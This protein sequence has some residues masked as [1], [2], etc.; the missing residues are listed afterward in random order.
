MSERWGGKKGN[1]ANKGGRNGGVGG[2]PGITPIM[3][4]PPRAWNDLQD[5]H[6]N[7]TRAQQ[8]LLNIGT[9]VLKSANYPTP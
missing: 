5:D 4:F 9:G 6:Q 2:T 3:A 8:T 7:I 1:E